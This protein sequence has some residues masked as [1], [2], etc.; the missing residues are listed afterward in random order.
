VRDAG[1]EAGALFRALAARLG[2]ALPPPERGTPGGDPRRLAIHESRRLA[3]LVAATLRYSNNQM[4]ELIGLATS[5]AL[6]GHSLGLGQ[7]AV[8][9]L[10]HL[11]GEIPALLSPPPVLPNHSGLAATARLTPR[12]LVALLVHGFAARPGVPALPAFLPTGGFEGTLD[13]RFDGPAQVLD[14]WAKTGTLDGASA[15]AGYLLEPK[16]APRAFAIMAAAPTGP[17]G[18]ETA[19]PWVLRARA[20][21]D[22]IIAEWLDAAPVIPTRG[23]R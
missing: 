11:Q 18:A 2:I 4:A 13:R 15:L 23:S 10:R 16:R 8:T 21:E 22:D 20:L 1:L 12:Q 9:V 3:D 6:V 17:T 5:R 19:T 7:S 14:V